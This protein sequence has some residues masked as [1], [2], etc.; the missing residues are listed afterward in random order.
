MPQ[1]GMQVADARP[2]K[3]ARLIKKADE[4]QALCKYIEMQPYYKQLN[5][6]MEKEILDMIVQVGRKFEK[7][8]GKVL[9]DFLFKEGSMHDFCRVVSEINRSKLAAVKRSKMKMLRTLPNEG[10]EYYVCDTVADAQDLSVRHIASVT[11]TVKGKHNLLMHIDTETNSEDGHMSHKLEE[12]CRTQASEVLTKLAELSSKLHDSVNLASMCM[13]QKKIAY[14]KSKK[15]MREQ[16][17]IMLT[18]AEGLSEQKASRM[19][20]GASVQLFK[21][22]FPEVKMA[23]GTV[24]TRKDGT[25][26]TMTAIDMALLANPGKTKKS[27]YSKGVCAIANEPI[28]H[29]MELQRSAV[30][31]KMQ[32]GASYMDAHKQVGQSNGINM[33]ALFGLEDDPDCVKKIADICFN[34]A[35]GIEFFGENMQQE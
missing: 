17:Q 14:E 33:G 19:L 20:Q 4:E 32:N 12:S 16:K 3:K 29:A 35:K 34:P 25:P 13:D 27:I 7:K 18:Q 31:F 24:A 9:Y 26:K 2:T 10:N 15:Q 23:D 21:G 22:L 1:G 30:T 5:A 8:E 11:L 28:H 6:H